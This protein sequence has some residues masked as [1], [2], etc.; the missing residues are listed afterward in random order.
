MILK[1]ENNFSSN[2]LLL[3]VQGGP[4]TMDEYAE[5]SEGRGT[6]AETFEPAEGWTLERMTLEEMMA[7]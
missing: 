5:L 7:E 6:L 3:G 2:K 1:H 4:D